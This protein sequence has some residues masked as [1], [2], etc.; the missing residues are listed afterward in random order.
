MAAALN[1]Y[2]PQ[3]DCD[4]CR[5]EIAKASKQIEAELIEL[6]GAADAVLESII[7]SANGES[8]FSGGTWLDQVQRLQAALLKSAANGT[9]AKGESK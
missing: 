9:P 2:H 8:I 3:I 4:L 5:Q 1:K 6:V 7:K